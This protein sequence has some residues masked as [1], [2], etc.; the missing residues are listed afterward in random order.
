MHIFVLYN[1]DGLKCELLGTKPHHNCFIWIDFQLERSND[2]MTIAIPTVTA[3]S[4]VYETE[5]G[6][7]TA[8]DASVA[9]LNIAIAAIDG[10]IRQLEDKA[11]RI[12]NAC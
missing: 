6:F 3:T 10:N 7:T 5:A 11:N 4:P 1:K 2:A 8:L 12:C 9:N